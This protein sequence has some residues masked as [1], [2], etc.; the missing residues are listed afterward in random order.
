MGQNRFPLI[1]Y[2]AVD[3]MGHKRPIPLEK[4]CLFIKYMEVTHSPF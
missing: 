2:K 4:V 3:P 1:G